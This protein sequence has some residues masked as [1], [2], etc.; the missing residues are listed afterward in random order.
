MDQNFETWILSQGLSAES[1]RLFV[2]AKKCYHNE[3]FSAA[4]LFSHLLFSNIIR[5][6]ITTAKAPVGFDG[7]HWRTIQ[8][9][10]NGPDI[11][12]K[13]VLEALV[14]IKPA[15]VFILSEDIRLQ[16]RFWKDRRNDCAHAKDS[17]IEAAHVRTFLF[18]LRTNLSK[19]VVNGSKDSLIEKIKVH[20]DPSRTKPGVNPD[21]L[22]SDIANAVLATELPN[23]FTTIFNEL[24]SDDSSLTFV[25]GTKNINFYNF[26]NR[27]FEIA[28]QNVRDACSIFI[29]KN[30]SRAFKFLRLHPSKVQILNGFPTLT[31]K[32]W[33]DELFKLSKKDIPLLV[34]IISEKLIDES[35]YPELFEIVYSRARSFKSEPH[36]DILLKNIG[37]YKFLKQK[38][39]GDLFENFVYANSKA[40]L[41]IKYL[42]V[43]VIDEEIAV[44]I[45]EGFNSSNYAWDVA[46]GLN[47]LFESNADKKAEYLKFVTAGIVKIP[48][49]IEA[50]ET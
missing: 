7:T 13:A 23:F 16:I 2:E 39:T 29:L 19:I 22:V 41:V 31:R 35:D 1:K 15:P 33:H 24:K 49:Q 14:Q 48:L 26:S 32:L 12:D 3:A 37:F 50:L 4:L 21:Y 25:F 47:N 30:E 44:A 38:I 34:S 42:E 18:F 27:V 6:R 45:Y 9:K 17:H 10:A 8:D 40:S 28:T 5:E 20:Y 11:W 46:T 43:N 36:E